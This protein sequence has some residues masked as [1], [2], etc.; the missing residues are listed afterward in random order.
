MLNTE[1]HITKLR[2]WVQIDKLV[3]SQLSRNSNA[4][5]I[6]E[7]NLDKVDWVGLSTNP[8][9]IQLL[10]QNLDKLNSTC[11]YLLSENPNIFTTE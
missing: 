9:A 4:I 11:W 5:H 7:N 2:E 10:E 3:W 1:T 6:L 8:N